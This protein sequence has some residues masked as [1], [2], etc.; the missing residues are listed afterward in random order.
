MP[1]NPSSPIRARAERTSGAVVGESVCVFQLFERDN[2]VEDFERELA[3][4]DAKVSAAPPALSRRRLWLLAAS[5]LAI[6]ALPDFPVVGAVIAIAGVAGALAWLVMSRSGKQSVDIRSDAVLS[7][8]RDN[9]VRRLDARRREQLTYEQD[10]HRQTDALGRLCETA[11]ACGSNAAE[12]EVQAQALCDWQDRRKIA[13]RERDKHSEQ[14]DELQQLRGSQPLDAIT[15]ETARLREKADTLVASADHALLEVVGGLSV[16]REQLSAMEQQARGKRIEWEGDRRERLTAERQRKEDNQLIGEA[17]GALRRAAESAR[18]TAD[19][20][21]GLAAAL[22]QWQ[23]DRKKSIARAEQQ[24]RDW[25][26]LQRLRGDRSLDEMED[27]AARLRNDATAR[28]ADV[29]EAALANARRQQP[30]E[31]TL[32]AL[33][34]E[35]DTALGD[36]RDERVRLEEFANTLPSVADA[37][38]ALDDALREQERVAHLERTLESTI[39]FLERAQEQIQRNIAPILSSTVLEWLPRVTAGRYNDCRI[40]PESL[41]VEVS[42]CD[43][44]RRAQLLSHGTAEQTYLLLRLALSRHLTKE[45]EVCPLILDDVVSASDAARK[46]VVLETL[47]AISESTQVVLFTHEDD[48]RDWAQERLAEP[49]NR[50]TEIPLDAVTV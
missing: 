40:D 29:G 43:G 21:F 28:A 23:E 6:I 11:A 31:E 36:W 14:W 30:G 49:L 45:G 2:V 18:V 8:H 25:D 34:D 38:D 39:C 7:V 32:T 12:P 10:L 26:E 42:G 50:L 13:M 35:A 48:V 24:G 33:E 44:W 17:Q 41:L 22:K 9:I 47:L 19:D 1:I 5:V 15:E 27:E 3:A 4:F 46:R 16:T 37:E 20:E